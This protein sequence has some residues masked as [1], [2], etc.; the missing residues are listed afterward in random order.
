M[1]TRQFFEMESE[2]KAKLVHGV[3]H[4]AGSRR[5]I[6]GHDVVCRAQIKQ[7]AQRGSI[8]TSWVLDGKVISYA[9]LVEA[10][11]N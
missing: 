9:K 3:E 7:G 2:A 10:L 6:E 8:A 4:V 5:S 11:N 1:N